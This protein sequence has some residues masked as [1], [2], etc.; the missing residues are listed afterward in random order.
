LIAGNFSALHGGGDAGSILNGCI[1]SNNVAANA[2][3]GCY[4]AN[5]ANS[6][7][8][9]CLV[10]SNIASYQGG[11]VYCN[12]GGSWLFN[13]TIVGNTATNQYGG[14]FG[15][16]AT[17]CIIYYNNSPSPGY[18]NYWNTSSGKIDYCCTPVSNAHGITNA[19]VFV[20]PAAGDFHLSA[21]S[22][23]INAGNN[24]Y[25]SGTNNN[26]Y[27][28]GTNDL[29][30]N[31]RIIGG[32]VDIGAYECQTPASVLSYAWAQKYGLPTD[33]S[34]DYADTDGDGMNN[35]QE[36]MSGTNPTNAASVLKMISATN[37]VSG[38]TVKWQSLT[39]VIY[40]LQRSTNLS[41]SPA[42][43]SIHSNLIRYTGTTSS[44]TDTTATNGN[45]FFYRIGVQYVY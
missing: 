41:T 23:C 39:N 31:P 13:C 42:F 7:L 1:I 20:N 37:S 18:N 14:V 27:A 28:S 43:T 3:G 8:N 15:A 29:D 38:M 24:S 16:S 19:P 34:A 9:N 2:G 22:L 45:S 4:S 10:I 21:N 32:T 5:S 12:F 35:W 36:W 33:G 40:Y 26:A 17:N 25:I 11:G 30:G 44:Y 6:G